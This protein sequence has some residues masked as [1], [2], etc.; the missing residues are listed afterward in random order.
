MLLDWK[1]P[2]Y[3]KN[4]A[5]KLRE[6]RPI[7]KALL[8]IDSFVFVILCSDKF[9]CLL[10]YVVKIAKRILLGQFVKLKENSRFVNWWELFYK[11][12]ELSLKL[13]LK[14]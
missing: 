13:N 3:L 11:L 8:S 1:I 9:L 5:E 4:D 10:K 12:V 7:R 6:V 14:T 2:K